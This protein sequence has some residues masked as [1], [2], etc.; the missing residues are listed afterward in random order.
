MIG[1]TKNISYRTSLLFTSCPTTTS[2]T[3]H[4]KVRN[5]LLFDCHGNHG[6]FT[7]VNAKVQLLAS[8][9]EVS[10]PPNKIS[11]QLAML[12]F[13]AY[14]ATFLASWS[15]LGNVPFQDNQSVPS[16]LNPSFVPGENPPQ[17]YWHMMVK[18]VKY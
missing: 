12:K 6:V 5:T 15:L 13:T 10:H 9:S 7:S 11:Y 16:V 4:C 17:Q 14:I 3:M 18:Q 8:C 2:N 1:N